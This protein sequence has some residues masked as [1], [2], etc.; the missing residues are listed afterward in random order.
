MTVA[1][2]PIQPALRLCLFSEQ[3][4][5]LIPS[6]PGLQK[7]TPFSLQ[8]TFSE[9]CGLQSHAEGKQHE[10]SERL[11]STEKKGGGGGGGGGW[12]DRAECMT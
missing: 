11:E 7:H 4:S 2:L 1:H 9:P 8:L 6:T 3:E 10:N 5:H 12:C